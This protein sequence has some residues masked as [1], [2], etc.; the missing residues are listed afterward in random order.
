MENVENYSNLFSEKPAEILVLA[1]RNLEFIF[2]FILSSSESI[3]CFVLF[4]AAKMMIDEK[5][6]SLNPF[7]IDINIV[8]SIVNKIIVRPNNDVTNLKKKNNLNKI[9]IKFYSRAKAG[10]K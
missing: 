2:I 9:L 7:G 6:G 8:C 4:S 3:F 10:V 5:V 1:E